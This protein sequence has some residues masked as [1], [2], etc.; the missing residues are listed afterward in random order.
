MLLGIWTALLEGENYVAKF[1]R[2]FG[3][4][5]G[6]LLTSVFWCKRFVETAVPPVPAVKFILCGF[7]NEDDRNANLA[8]TL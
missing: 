2:G 8:L 7:H 3:V 1:L 4:Y 6:R 5:E